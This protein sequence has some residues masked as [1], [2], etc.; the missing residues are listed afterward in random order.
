VITSNYTDAYDLISSE[1][2]LSTWME[3]GV[4]SAGDGGWVT[5]S[6]SASSFVSANVFVSLP[7]ISGDTADTGIPVTARVRN[8]VVAGGTLSFQTRLYQTNDTYCNNSWGKTEAI[9][10]LP[11]S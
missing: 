10:P 8:V 1:P 5:V 9:Q 3:G 11:L 6:T 4:T 2:I 7:H